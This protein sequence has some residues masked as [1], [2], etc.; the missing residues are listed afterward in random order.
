MT[1]EN[2][3]LTLPRDVAEALLSVLGRVGDSTNS[4]YSPS[5]GPIDWLY[6]VLANR[7][8]T[9]GGY[10]LQV[11]ENPDFRPPEWDEDDG[12]YRYFLKLVRD[13]EI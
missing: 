1:G 12:V 2:I 3:D 6:N 8:V 10:V 7:G 13:G 5:D 11:E 9:A 4:E